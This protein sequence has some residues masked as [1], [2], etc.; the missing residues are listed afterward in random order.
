[1]TFNQ[2]SFHIN[3]NSLDNPQPDHDRSAW[4]CS[5]HVQSFTEI[6]EWWT[7]NIL[8]VTIF[9]SCCA[10]FHE[11]S[12]FGEIPSIPCS[13]PPYCRRH[14]R[15]P[16]SL[17]VVQCYHQQLTMLKIF[18]CMQFIGYLHSRIPQTRWVVHVQLHTQ[19]C[20]V[21]CSWL[22]RCNYI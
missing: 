5:F 3:A 10:E 22:L 21:L 1:M 12:M 17:Q 14:H 18:T 8:F 6:F 2:G 9:A 11:F 13:W 16:W 4:D 20:T 19:K 7:K 15:Q